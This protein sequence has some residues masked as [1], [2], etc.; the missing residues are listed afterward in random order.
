MDPPNSTPP[1][2]IGIIVCSTRTPRVCPQV[3]QFVQ[4]TILS[5][6]PDTTN[7][8]TPV[9]TTHLIDLA[10]W[11][12]PMYNEPGIPS[13]IKDPSQYAHAHTRAWSAEITRYDAFIFVT[14]QYN[15]GYPAVVKNAIDYLYNEW[16]GKPAAVVSYG[17]HGGGKCNQQLREVLAGVRMRV[18]GKGVE[19]AF[20]GREVLV[21]AAG[22]ED[23]GCGNANGEGEEVVG[24]WLE[25]RK[26]I[27]EAY[28]EILGVLE[29]V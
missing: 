15:W 11:N 23:I 18:I 19:L 12:L 4:N 21:K 29:S 2:K 10:T 3:A 27:E 24:I 16:R 14:P 25:E 8:H 9:P 6:K 28:R 26:G 20:P 13:Q 5:I 1:P 7:P 17:G 22:G